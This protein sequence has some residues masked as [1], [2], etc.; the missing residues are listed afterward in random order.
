MSLEGSESLGTK[1]LPDQLVLLVVTEPPDVK[2]L[3]VTRESPVNPVPWGIRVPKE[4][5]VVMVRWVHR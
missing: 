4:V 3:R 5:L 2:V 1:V